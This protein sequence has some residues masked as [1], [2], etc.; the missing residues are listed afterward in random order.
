MICTI[1]S[2]EKPVAETEVSAVIVPAEDGQMGVLTRHAPFIG[3]LG[4]G[5][6][7]LRTAKGDREYVVD[8]G[9]VQIHEDK[10]IV[11]SEYIVELTNEDPAKVQL[12]IDNLGETPTEKAE[13][14]RLFAVLR[15][16]NGKGDG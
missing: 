9:F 7:I 1:N 2:P 8:G 12:E 15:A 6:L 14:V 3:T 5:K 11:L 16:L 13:K 10:I 4:L